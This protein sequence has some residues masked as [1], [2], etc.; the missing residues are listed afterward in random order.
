MG[1]HYENISSS[2]HGSMA[3]ITVFKEDFSSKLLNDLLAAIIEKNQK[4]NS[5]CRITRKIVFPGTLKKWSE[6]PSDDELYFQLTNLLNKPSFE[7]N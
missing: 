6:L 1:V 4:C 7:F 2:F 3:I 5:L